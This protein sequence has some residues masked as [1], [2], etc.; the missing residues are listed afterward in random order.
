M[1]S[2]VAVALEYLENTWTMKPLWNTQLKNTMSN[3]WHGVQ[4][5]SLDFLEVMMNEIDYSDQV[6]III[7][8]VKYDGEP[9]GWDVTV[10]HG[11]EEL[12]SG[13]APTFAGVYDIAY[14]IIVGGDKHSNYEYNEWALFDANRRSNETN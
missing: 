13:T 3:T 6:T 11:S 7:T 4:P 10:D 2:S 1:T 8:K 9:T 14:S 5:L 12:G